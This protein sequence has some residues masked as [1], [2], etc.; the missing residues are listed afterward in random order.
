MPRKKQ[1]G[2][3]RPRLRSAAP[4]GW[5]NRDWL[6]PCW[7][8]GRRTCDGRVSVT[9]IRSTRHPAACMPRS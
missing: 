1:I 9:F 8:A 2:Y 7:K 5:T 4:G 3:E 6:G